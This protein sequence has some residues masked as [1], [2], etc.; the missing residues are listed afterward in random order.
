MNAEFVNLK[1]KFHDCENQDSSIFWLFDDDEND[2]NDID[3]EFDFEHDDEHDEFEWFIDWIFRLVTIALW[4]EV[5]DQNDRPHA[6]H[7]EID[8]T[9]VRFELLQHD[10]N[11]DPVR[12]LRHILQMVEIHEV[13]FDEQ[14]TFDEND[15]PVQQVVDHGDEHEHDHDEIDVRWIDSQPHVSKPFVDD[16]EHID[17]SWT[18]IVNLQDDDEHD[19]DEQCE[20]DD[21]WWIVIDNIVFDEMRDRGKFK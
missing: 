14:F 3:H 7:D 13:L 18:S 21:E 2:E 12:H 10:E 6:H 15:E 8:E 1:R 9:L 5:H 17:H 4:F 11:D 16:H 19:H 20:I